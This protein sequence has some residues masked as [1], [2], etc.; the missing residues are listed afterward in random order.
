MSGAPSASKPDVPSTPKAFIIPNRS[1][2]G[3]TISEKHSAN[4][5]SD[6]DDG[7]SMGDESGNDEAR[8]L[9]NKK[10]SSCWNKM[11]SDFKLIF[12]CNLQL[13]T[14]SFPIGKRLPWRRKDWLTNR[15]PSSE[16][17][18][19]WSHLARFKCQRRC[20]TSG[21]WAAM[22]ENNSWTFW[23]TRLTWTRLVL[24][25]TKMN[26]FQHNKGAWF[27]SQQC[28]LLLCLGLLS[29]VWGAHG[30]FRKSSRPMSKNHSW[31]KRRKNN[32]SFPDGLTRNKWSQSWNGQR[33][34]AASVENTIS[35][36][37]LNLHSTYKG[38]W[39]MIICLSK[40]NL[41]P[42]NTWISALIDSKALH[43]R[44]GCVLQETQGAGEE[45]WLGVVGGCWP[46]SSPLKSRRI[47]H[48][49]PTH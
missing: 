41:N 23:W 8:V 46:N 25:G 9:E 47:K 22:E 42:H 31:R 3:P 7:D 32:K 5:K 43:Q 6:G 10:C 19:R 34:L 18:A 45:T 37:S 38:P 11:E 28:Y 40:L 35:D 21:S 30:P 14:R 15:T 44:C 16:G 26:C 13:P 39:Y 49:Q 36:F 48:K 29:A 1:P 12:P 27:G 17:Y 24:G 20:M 4:G 2:S 33:L